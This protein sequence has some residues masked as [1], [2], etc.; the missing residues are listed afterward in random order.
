MKRLLNVGIGLVWLAIMVGTVLVPLM[1]RASAQTIAY[2]YTDNTFTN[3]TGPKQSGDGWTTYEHRGSGGE[4]YSS[5]C[6]ARINTKS[7]EIGGSTG[8]LTGSCDSGEE[9]VIIQPPPAQQYVGVWLDH[10]HVN[11]FG[12]IY[13][14]VEIDD[15]L[16][17]KITNAAST[18]E[19]RQIINGFNHKKGNDPA[20]ANDNPAAEIHIFTI[21]GGGNNN[22]V[23]QIFPIRF[24]DHPNFLK[25]FTWVDAGTIATS[26][27]SGV[28]FVQNGT[29][30]YLDDG[31]GRSSDSTCQSQITAS[32]EAANGSLIIRSSG[33]PHLTSGWLDEIFNAGRNLSPDGAG[34]NV[35]NQINVEIANT[36][37]AKLPPG[38]G[39]RGNEAAGGTEAPATCESRSGSILG[40]IACPVINALDGGIDL[41][42]KYIIKYLTVP[43]SYY[44]NNPGLESSWRTM[45]NIAYIILVP[46]MLIMVISTA[47]GFNFVDAYT[48]KKAMP[49]FIAATIFIAISWP[50]TVF[51]MDFTNAVGKGI[52]GL[53]TSSFTP[54]D[55]IGPR[56]ITLASIFNANAGQGVGSAAAGF[57]GLVVVYFATGASIFVIFSLALSAAVSLMIAFLTLVFRQLLLVALM[58]F[59]PLAILAWIFPGNDKLWKLWWGTFSKLLLMF[60]LIMIIIG[61]GRIF[62]YTIM[63]V[64]NSADVS[65]IDSFVEVIFKVIAYIAPYVFIPA[66]FKIAGGLFATV[67]GMV[68]D[69][70]KGFFDKQRAKRDKERER[71][72][73]L[74]SRNA[75]YSETGRFGKFAKGMNTMAGWSVDPWSSANIKLGTKRGRAL[76]SELNLKKLKH[77]QEAAQAMSSAGFNDKAVQPLYREVTYK[78]TDDNGVE[79]EE[80]IKRWDGTDKGLNKVA[81]DLDLAGRRTG[82]AT[83]DLGS[84]A[85]KDNSAFLLSA[86]KNEEYGRAS[87]QSAAALV[88]ASQGF[89]GNENIAQLSEELNADG[90]TF[91]NIMK[92]NLELAASKSAGTRPGYTVRTERYID[93]DGK[94]QMRFVQGDEITMGELFVR[95]DPQTLGSIKGAKLTENYQEGA[96]IALTAGAYID[97]KTNP[98]VVSIKQADAKRVA[99]AKLDTSEAHDNA[100]FILNQVYTGYNTVDTKNR[101]RQIKIRAEIINRMRAAGTAS[102]SKTS[103]AYQAIEAQA[104][105][106]VDSDLKQLRERGGVSAAF[107]ALGGGGA[108]PGA[109]PGGPPGAPPPPPPPVISDRRLKR[110]ITSLGHTE[111]DI[112]IYQFQYLWSDQ[113][114]VGVMA[115]DLLSTHPDAVIVAEDRFYRVNYALLGFNM[116]TIEEWEASTKR[117]V[118]R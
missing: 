35:S 81:A 9:E 18:C 1:S 56:E 10:S 109:A 15:E 68:N 98:N 82:D 72:K 59:A 30:P 26:D 73:E 103:R 23:E 8:T 64:G 34:C 114:Y 21:L 36:Q 48:V 55:G 29:G 88:E 31:N 14:D 13:Y 107:N 22:C 117:L 116:M 80:K 65:G 58:L 57:A 108:P 2:T 27:L 38:S 95:Q 61:A 50:I 78:Y 105:A 39:E 85:V 51:L 24:N 90:G 91:G 37:N 4:Y 52:L 67:T 63:N 113:V 92:T 54:V 83:F 62:A 69:R 115:Q 40:W 87:L 3:I 43:E 110:N 75:R 102:L 70:K 53:M 94:E 99:G 42:D 84:K 89:I 118:V 16:E 86:F 7:G 44:K 104:T 6:A 49:R 33:G 11:V 12:K 60:P 79:H 28:F 112:Q 32:L 100:D 17:Y 97:D 46:I 77:T 66:T 111:N 20:N 106:K 47:L 25:F 74:G 76:A 45:R 101:V 93:K 96:Q 19:G 71:N 5:D 41:L